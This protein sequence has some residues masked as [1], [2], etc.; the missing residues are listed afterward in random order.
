MTGQGRIA[1]PSRHHTQSDDPGDRDQEDGR[2]VADLRQQHRRVAERGERGVVAPLDEAGPEEHRRQDHDEVQELE[3][4][5]RGVLRKE[6][7]ARE[8]RDAEPA[9][10]P[11]GQLPAGR[12]DEAEEDEGQDAVEDEGVLGAVAGEVVQDRHE[13]REKQ[14]PLV[15]H[16]LE[17]D[18][19]A[20]DV[21]APHGRETSC[22]VHAHG[23]PGQHHLVHH[24]LEPEGLVDDEHRAPD[25]DHGEGR[26]VEPA[27]PRARTR[28]GRRGSCARAPGRT[29]R[30]RRGRTSSRCW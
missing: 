20:L 29:A 26:P 30:T 11:P 18:E 17:D 5:A 15:H 6:R 13:E 28:P 7:Q 27:K 24:D 8:E 14:L 2:L 9:R 3:P 21:A 1:L 10:L 25:G 23:R 4:A 12:V 19:G 22:E 16:A